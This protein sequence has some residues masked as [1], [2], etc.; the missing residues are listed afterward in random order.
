MSTLSLLQV[1]GELAL[2]RL[3]PLELISQS[4]G[5][6]WAFLPPN[7]SFRSELKALY[8]AM[9]RTFCLKPEAIR[10]MCSWEASGKV[11]AKQSEHASATP[12]V[13]ARKIPLELRRPRQA[14]VEAN[15]AWNLL[16]GGACVVGGVAM[17]AWIVVNHRAAGDASETRP[18]TDIQRDVVTE[19]SAA[20]RAANTKAHDDPTRGT[21]TDRRAIDTRSRTSGNDAAH[22][23]SAAK[24]MS[25]AGR[26]S[27]SNIQPASRQQSREQTLRADNALHHASRVAPKS[28]ADN[29]PRFAL[30]AAAPRIV[31]LHARPSASAAGNYS[32]FAPSPLGKS[33][34]DSLSMS[35]GTHVRE[36]AATRSTEPVDTNSTEWMNHMAQRRVTDVPDRFS[37]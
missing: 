8:A 22:P 35:A 3:R 24:R 5:R 1:Q 11:E 25:I 10:S 31:S 6:E 33:D 16:A 28:F 36:I 4:L 7:V 2:P 14:A 23:E 34:Y 17:L 32:P 15:R 12:A 37:K 26:S 21:S 29:A 19:T 27:R 20:S 13:T 30:R 9:L 18:A